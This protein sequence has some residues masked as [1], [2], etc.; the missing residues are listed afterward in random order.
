[1]ISLMFSKKIS[2]IDVL[3]KSRENILNEYLWTLNPKER[4]FEEK[5]PEEWE[6]Y[7]EKNNF[8]ERKFY[9]KVKRI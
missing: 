5:R 6:K 2:I 8:K 3:G 9:E 1:M 7:E 4:Q